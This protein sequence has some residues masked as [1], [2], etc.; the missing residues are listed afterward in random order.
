MYEWSNLEKLLHIRSYHLDHTRS[1]LNS[2]VKQ[3]WAC[4]VLWWGTTRESQ[5]LYV[6]FIFNSFHNKMTNV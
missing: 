6:S 4:L 1:H 5:V 3:G 2:E